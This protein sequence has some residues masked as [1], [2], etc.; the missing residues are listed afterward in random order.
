MVSKLKFNT[1]DFIND[2]NNNMSLDDLV[3]KYGYK[4]KS[5]IF[6]VI[7]K[8][9]LPPRTNR[10]TKEKLELLKLHYPQSEWD[11]ILEVLYPFKKEDIITKAYKL[12]IKRECYGYSPEDEQFLKENY[13]ILSVEELST[14]LNKSPA[15][16]MTKANKMGIIKMEKWS[17][18]EIDKLKELYPYYTNEELVEFFPNRSS[19]AIMSMATMK[20]DL[21]KD[22]EYLSERYYKFE[23]ERMLHGLIEYA[24]ELGRTPTTRE[25]QE[26]KKL[27]GIASYHRHFGSYSEACKDAGL[28]VNACLFGK[29]FHLESKNGDLCLSKKEKEITDLLIDNNIKFEKE[30]LYKDILNDDTLTNIRCDWLINDNIVVEYFGMAEKDY[31]KERMDKK[32]SLCKERGLTL[33]SLTRN[34]IWSN[35]KGLIKKFKELNIDIKSVI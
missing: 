16:I 18:D 15:S 1:H 13:L 34:D 25:I 30:V 35:F 17:Q 19:N 22:E 26:N 14:K 20:L 11:K 3:L 23:K 12:K 27:S 7:K 2:Y 6:P 5:S 8:L 24:N 10:W 28:E 9:G 4:N 29:S 21:Y 32:I 31:Y 33:V